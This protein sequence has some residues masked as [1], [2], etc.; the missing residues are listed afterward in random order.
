[1]ETNA[2]NES[3][4][5]PPRHWVGPEELQASYWSDSRVQEKRGQEFFE[6]PIEY[7]DK[8]DKSA[9][10]GI[11][12]R[13]FLTIMGASMAMASFSCARRPVHKIIPYVVSPEE[14][15]PGEALWYA[16]TYKDSGDHYGILVKAREGRPIKVEGNPDHPYS[17]GRLGARAQASVLSLYDPDRLRTPVALGRA[18]RSRREI[19][20]KDADAAI[21]PRLKAAATGSGRV[22]VLTG[23][24][25]SD[26]TAAVVRDFVGAFG[27]GAHVEHEALGLDEIAQAQEL[28]YGSAVTPSIRL[29]K[30][31]VVLSLGAD[32]LAT[33]PLAV[34]SAGEWIRRRKLDGGAKD[35]SRLYV[36]EP[37]FTL[38][39][40]NA[41]ER[42]PVRPGDEL[43]IALALANEL[44][45][46]GRVS[47]DAS[48]LQGYTP[49]AV[50]QETGLAG[51]A[52]TLRKLAR[53]LWDARGK[54]VVLA[55]SVQSRSE[56]ALGLQ[57]AA[58]L[59]NS[60]LGNDGATVVA[61]A[62]A[63]S[64]PPSFAALHKL[65]SDMAA[66]SVDVLVLHGVNPAFTAPYAMLQG[67]QAKT[68]EDALKRVP[69]VIALSDREDETARLADYVLPVHHF[70]ENWGDST[71]RKGLH[72]L[73]QPVLAPIHDSRSFEDALLAWLK[74]AG[75]ARGAA[76]QAD[77]WHG[78]LMSR[79]RETV[80]REAGSGS[81]EAFWE[82]SLR[83]G[84]VDT[85]KGGAD[86]GPRAMRMSALSS[87]PKYA[88]SADGSL[89]LAL[90]ETIQMHDGRFAN[91]PWLQ[92]MPDPVTTVTWD[93]FVALAPA[94][95]AKHGLRDD[96]VV[97][98]ASGETRVRLP[99]RVQVGLHPSVA[100]VAIGYGRR[101]A[102]K[103]GSGTGV[104]MY[105]FVRMAN[106]RPVFSGAPVTLRKTGEF[107]KLA[108]TQWHS[109]S[110]NRPI[111]NDITLAQFRADP[112]A[113]NATDPELR[114]HEVP[115][116]WPK[117][118]YKGHRWGM[119]ID[120][121]SCIGCQACV[122]ACQAENNIPVV[123]RN[124]VRTG[125][126]MHWIRIDRYYTGSPERPD[127]VFQPMLCQ[128]CENAPCETVCPVLATVH[129]DEGLNVQVYNRCVG[130]RYCQNNCPYKVR[131]FNFFD[132]WKSYE[133]SMNLAWNP[134][135]TVRTRGIMEKCTFCVQ[136]IR[137]AK[138]RAKDLGG[139]ASER[140]L[141][142]ACQQTCP[143]DAIVFGDIN[144]PTTRVSRLHKDP[145]AYRV[146]ETLNTRP[147]ISYLAKVRNVDRDG[148]PVRGGAKGGHHE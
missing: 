110:E 48:A 117:H 102:G 32:F 59:L 13:D 33:G 94:T 42:Y 30:A 67:A 80:F 44:A 2:S 76:A 10:G 85:L 91:N 109:V 3:R 53:E 89:R 138:D 46:L 56:S 84:V 114:M 47:G 82:K 74:G 146:L 140:D 128:H 77:D 60:L 142:T 147:T 100:A 50:A 99:V 136:R 137:D 121:T 11:A 118:E 86:A 119:A 126:Q 79:W 27:A 92:E 93:N 63:P 9:Q 145:R 5:T 90:Y 72:S 125:R 75:L 68:F 101:S 81:F 133:G 8:L 124:Q 25:R 61:S 7:L 31:R 41:D 65:V 39:G 51:G 127:V 4:F 98:L 123:G 16:S 40:A 38:T 66:G 78:Y 71:P 132:H 12:R 122:V 87:L 135:V 134:D 43:K 107:Y 120:L 108:A 139:K 22:R 97:E 14:V 52:G 144:D 141:K 57:V 112:H 20:W 29:D 26:S 15:I 69:L 54:C 96:D 83:D 70:L 37:A 88:P 73:Q 103:V 55:G 6:K 45:T 115:S 35:Q 104:D 1:M 148:A 143:T 18:D 130:T 49:D 24:L 17:G 111:V 23:A 34:T 129:D 116:I 105:P 36:F 19:S 131:R 113:E 21:I 58:N 106:G 62:D 28:C 64:A 95:A